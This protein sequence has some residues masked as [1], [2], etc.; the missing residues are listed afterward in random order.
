MARAPSLGDSQDT[1]PGYGQFSFGPATG[2]DKEEDE[3]RPCA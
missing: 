3:V 1:D 2:K